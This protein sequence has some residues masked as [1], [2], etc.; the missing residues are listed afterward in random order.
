MRHITKAI[1]FTSLFLAGGT[2]LLAACGDDSGGGNAGSGGKLS[3]G[4]S[5]NGSGGAKS[6]G[7]S[8]GGAAMVGTGGNAQI[9]GAPTAGGSGM[10]GNSSG[11]NAAGGSPAGGANTGGVGT[12]GMGGG[13]G[14]GGE[15][16]GGGAGGAMCRR[17]G[18]QD[19]ELAQLNMLSPLPALPADPTNQYAD[20]VLARALGQR[21]FFDKAFSGAIG[22]AIQTVNPAETVVNP[23]GNTGEAGKVACASCHTG[24]S[25][26]DRGSPLQII[27]LGTGAGTRNA[28]G[29]VNS[30]FYQWTN[31]G[32]R[33][34]AQWELSVVVAENGVLLNSN[35]LKIAH[36]IFDKYNTEYE[37]IFGALEPEIG[38]NATR[39]PAE[40]KL[41]VAAFDNMAVGDKAIINRILVNYGKAIQ[42]YMRQVVSG[43]SPFDQLMA[44]QPST[45]SDSAMRGAQLFVG[46]AKCNSC[47]STSHFSDDGFHNLGVPEVDEGIV[48]RVHADDLGRFKDVPGLMTS[49]FNSAGSFSDDAVAGAA[50]LA[51]LTNPASDSTKAAFR[52]PNLRGVADTAP[53]MHAGQFATLEAVVNFYDAGGGTPQAGTT[54]AAGLT[55]LNLT[56]QEK[57]DL[58]EFLKSLSGDAVTPALLVD[59]SATP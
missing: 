34:S 7:S 9:G 21:F 22:A 41:G 44:C 50:R 52:T 23:L 36:R 53:Y 29:V 26:D 3:T 45:I 58:V 30:S 49:L 37:A 48:G 43:N 32:G 16:A 55:V 11:G 4:G 19:P 17:S 35:R 13:G 8:A 51:G 12:A 39:F 38:T 25:M 31:W 40:G 56:S 5:S 27:S 20:N 1:G 47:H 33:F 24:P 6:G 15:V 42:A 14:A 46:K 18:F 28:P 10:A 57:A 59:T 2:G 54:K